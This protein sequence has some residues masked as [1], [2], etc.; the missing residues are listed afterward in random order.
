M[1]H[2]SWARNSLQEKPSLLPGAPVIYRPVGAAYLVLHLAAA[3]AA[4]TDPRLRLLIEAELEDYQNDFRPRS[5]PYRPIQL[6]LVARYM[7][8]GQS[9]LGD[10]QTAVVA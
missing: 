9:T 10:M 1:A 3:W 8:L 6:E 4:T 2:S 5:E 7:R